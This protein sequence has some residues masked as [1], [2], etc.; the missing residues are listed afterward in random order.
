MAK[1]PLSNDFSRCWATMKSGKGCPK[2]ICDP[3]GHAIPYCTHHM[4]VG[5]EAFEVLM[6]D[7]KPEIFG[8]I[9]IARHNI[10][11]GY[12]FVYWGDLRYNRKVKSAAEDHTIEFIPN[13]YRYAVGGRRPVRMT[14]EITCVRSDQVRGTI[15]PTQQTG[16]NGNGGSTVRHIALTTAMLLSIA[17]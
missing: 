9:L 17:S 16:P 7:E 13:E 12:K 6:H 4:K 11:K 1:Q 5:D 8:K 2:P 14:A 10:P 3:Q 15:D